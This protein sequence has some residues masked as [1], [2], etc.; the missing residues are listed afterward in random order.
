MPTQDLTRAGLA[1][2]GARPDPAVL[3]CCRGRVH[4]GLSRPGS[5]TAPFS[6]RILSLL[7]PNDKQLDKRDHVSSYQR[8]CA[9]AAPS[10]RAITTPAT[11]CDIEPHLRM[12]PGQASIGRSV[13]QRR[14]L[15][16]LA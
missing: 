2:A 14:K 15:A 3:A 4:V 16:W 10:R 8:Q 7:Q 9:E 6:R 12:G 5:L 1:Q 11:E 13:H